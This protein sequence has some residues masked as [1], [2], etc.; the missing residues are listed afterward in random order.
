MAA[1]GDAEFSRQQLGHKTDVLRKDAEFPSTPGITTD[2]TSSEKVLAS[3]V[4]ISSRSVAM[5]KMGRG[6]G[7]GLLLDH[8]DAALHVE[9]ALGHVVVLAVEDFFEATDR[10]R[11]GNVLT[12][13]AGEDFAPRGRAG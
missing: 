6:A 5:R 4:T 11:D 8:V 10:F 1:F 12:G 9:V 2:S 13:S 3:G 7:G